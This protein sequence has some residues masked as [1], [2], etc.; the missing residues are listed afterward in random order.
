MAPG[1]HGNLTTYGVLARSTQPS[2]AS[3]GNCGSSSGDDLGDLLFTPSSTRG[4][5]NPTSIAPTPSRKW[6][7]LEHDATSQI[8]QSDTHNTSGGVRLYDIASQTKTFPQLTQE[9]GF[10][11]WNCNA[12][13]DRWMLR[14]VEMWKIEDGRKSAFMNSANSKSSKQSLLT[15]TNLSRNQSFSTY[16]DVASHPSEYLN[17]KKNLQQNVEH[18]EQ[19]AA[20]N[21]AQ[22]ENSEGVTQNKNWRD[23]TN[24]VTSNVEEEKAYGG[25]HSRIHQ[26]VLTSYRLAALPPEVERLRLLMH[27]INSSRNLIRLPYSPRI[28]RR[29]FYDRCFGNGDGPSPLGDD[30]KN[31][32]T[33]YNNQ[34]ITL[35]RLRDKVL[36]IIEDLILSLMAPICKGSVPQKAFG[37]PPSPSLSEHKLTERNNTTGPLLTCSSHNNERCSTVREISDNA[38]RHEHEVKGPLNT[39]PSSNPQHDK[40]MAELQ[41]MFGQSS[42]ASGETAHF[43]GQEIRKNASHHDLNS[44]FGATTSGQ[45]GNH[46]L[47]PKSLGTVTHSQPPSAFGR[48]KLGHIDEEPSHHKYKDTTNSSIDMSPDAE[49]FHNSTVQNKSPFD[50]SS[51]INAAQSTLQSPSTDAW[52]S[53]YSSISATPYQSLETIQHGGYPGQQFHL[54]RQTGPMTPAQLRYLNHQQ[55]QSGMTNDMPFRYGQQQFSGFRGPQ[56]MT[57]GGQ[58]GPNGIWIPNDRYVRPPAT[59]RLAPLYA[60]TTMWP[61][62]Q[63]LQPDSIA[64]HPKWQ[65]RFGTPV[66]AVLRDNRKLPYLERSKEM[67][68]RDETASVRFQ[69]L[70]RSQPP[71]FNVVTS[72]ANVPFVETARATR[73]AEWGVMKIGNV[74]GN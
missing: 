3:G 32:I 10:R 26:K 31:T 61:A 24:T 40:M 45:H 50:G 55:M 47:G 53:R 17:Q 8:T 15:S 59:S 36:Q 22:T 51:S 69:N 13:D 44:I 34:E 2:I 57:P 73:P 48:F 63:Q 19:H 54:A 43:A 14:P 4:K 65:N 67:Y 9:Q 58:Y 27:D 68:P 21:Y 71:S 23:G 56:A 60:R 41:Q 35:E 42:L 74:S 64:Q 33:R 6:S 52:S 37:A 29:Y 18:L 5:S 16:R 39:D 20:A 70:T 66:P 28:I 25:H 38:G 72:E 49:H 46:Q 7:D 30:E 62:V 11:I 12:F 1:Q